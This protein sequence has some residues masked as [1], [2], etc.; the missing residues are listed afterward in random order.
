[1]TPASPSPMR[2]R[3]AAV[4][5]VAVLALVTMSCGGE[6]R[7][8][9]GRT[10]E[11]RIAETA[12]RASGQVAD[13]LPTWRLV[14]WEPHAGVDPTDLGVGVVFARRAEDKG[15][16]FGTDTLIVRSAPNVSAAAVGAM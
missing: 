8:P 14:S 1:M 12:A 3:H 10:G 15:A 6:Q 9:A 2:V 4:G 13:V 7:A 16:T 5:T 11:S